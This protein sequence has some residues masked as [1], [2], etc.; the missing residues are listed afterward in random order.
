[1]SADVRTRFAP[2]PTGRLHLGNVRTALFNF[3]LAEASG[4]AFVVRAEDI[5][6]ER[7]VEAHLDAQLDDLR[8]LGLHWHE[9]PDIGGRHGPYRQSE[10][11]DTYRDLIARLQE[12]GRVYP[13]WRTGSELREY[14]QQRLAAGQPPIYDRDWG[15]L[16]DVEI[17]RR[18]ETGQ[19][20]VLRF[21]VP[22]GGRVVF[23]DLIRG[24]Q[25]FAIEDIGDFVVRRSDGTP[26]FFFSNAV[27][28]AL[29]GITHVL[30]GEDH[31]SNTPR[32]LLVLEALEM[33]P[34]RYGHL[35]LLVGDD[36]VPLSKRRGA[37]GIHELREAGI[38][39]GALANYLA[40][41]GH[42]SDSNALLPLPALA[43]QFDLARI[44]RA[45][46]HYD[47][48]QLAHWQSLAVHAAT[49]EEL[50]DWAGPQALARVPEDTRAAFLRAVQPNLARPADVGL[51]AG[52]LFGE[53]PDYSAAVGAELI[54]T[55]ADFFDAALAAWEQGARDLEPLAR[56]LGA[57]LDVRGRR[58][59]RPLR[60]ALTGLDHG[61]ELGPLLALMPPAAV[62]AR[63]ARFSSAAS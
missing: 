21:R 55:G 18:G 61:P 50:A 42:A 48:A 20:P 32:Q 16:A 17:S 28:D 15:R 12:R 49:C 60:L 8:W 6:P 7:S 38:M 37:A 52:I 31:L 9:G 30:R 22:D 40:R 36:D 47:P 34:P 33:P 41:L 39:P 29:M 24:P 51:W 11:H 53:G 1:M 44:G 19:R 58:L 27:D 4:G 56:A 54:E 10:R 23:E 3:L 13:C 63:L 14:R 35:P 45:P 26:G 57:A 43:E 5:D 62:R 25:E 2:S 59:Y 46:A